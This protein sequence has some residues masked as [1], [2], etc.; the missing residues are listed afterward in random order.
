MTNLT[1]LNAV[2]LD[3]W[4][5]YLDISLLIE[6]SLNPQT[7]QLK[8]SEL[9]ELATKLPRKLIVAYLEKIALL[10]SGAQRTINETQL[11]AIPAYIGNRELDDPDEYSNQDLQELEELSSYLDF[12]NRLEFI[13]TNEIFDRESFINNL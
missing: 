4:I 2:Q 7:F 11:S 9:T 13:F 12:L 8:D 10:Q 1:L 5:S 6:E 3:N